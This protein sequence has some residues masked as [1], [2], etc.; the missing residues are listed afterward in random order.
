MESTEPSQQRGAVVSQLSREIVQLHA[1]MYGRGPVKARSYLQRDFAL[2]V[3]EEI[4]TIAERTLIDAGNG[5]HVQETRHKFQ[6]AV[7]DQFI[8]IAENV[9]GRT[10]RVFMSQVDIDEGVATELFLFEPEPNGEDE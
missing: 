4:F 9:T 8:E 7:R 3:L 10:V 1:R 5:P 6:E 2:C